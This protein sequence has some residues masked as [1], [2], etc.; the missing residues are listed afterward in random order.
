[1]VLSLSL[2]PA[3]Y[4]RASEPCH[5]VHSNL[6]GLLGYL[7]TL[8]K[9]NICHFFLFV[10]DNILVGNLYPSKTTHS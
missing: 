2:N 7:G 3:S 5:T 10:C 6:A 1:M 8:V 4:P 9:L